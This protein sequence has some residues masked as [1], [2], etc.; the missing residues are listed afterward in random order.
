MTSRRRFNQQERATLY[1]AA[2][3]ACTSCGAA[4]DSGWHGDHIRPYSR[5]G[6]TDVINGQALCPPCNLEKGDRVTDDLR[7]W[8]H[9]AIRKFDSK[10]ATDFLVCATPGAGKTR[11]ALTLARRLLNQQTAQ[12]VVVV[13][14]TDALRRQWADEAAEFGIDLM[15]VSAPEDYDK[16]GYHGCVV[17]YAQLATGAGADLLRRTTRLP[18]VALIDEI[19]HAGD[20]RAWG[21]GVQRA[22]ERAVRR[23]GL[24]GTPWRK[25]KSSPIPF[26][27][28][29]AAGKVIVDSSYEYGSAV[30][31]GVCRRV[32][33]H[34]YDGEARWVDCGTI[35][36]AEIGEKM[37]PEDVA[38]VLDTILDPDRDWMPGILAA[39]VDALRELRREMPDAGGLVVADR[40]AQ[41]QKYARMLEEMTGEA[42][43]VAVSGDPNAPD[44]IEEFR[45]GR[46]SWLVAVKMVSEGVDIKRLAVGVYATKTRT[47]LFFRQVVGRFVRTRPD[48]EINAKLFIPAV[49][50]FTTHAKEIEDELRHQLELEVQRDEA[51][52]REAEAGQQ[53]FEL[54][55]PISAS[56]AQFAS[57]I[58]GGRQN[59]A[60]VHARAEQWCRDRGIPVM[61]AANVINDVLSEGQPVAQVVITPAT[62]AQPRIRHEKMLRGDINTLVG[63][64]AYRARIEPRE[65]NNELLK[66]GFPTRARCDIDQL[67]QIRDHLA[68]WLSGL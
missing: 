19:H 51:A 58:F 56:E 14:P 8:Q 32:E 42:A 16:A 53:M 65:V 17:T 64:I 23:I 10:A 55:E 25:D 66:S 47:P 63:K 3:G 29:D 61:Y 35:V 20:E 37:R 11:L 31:D 48:E 41:A 27:S 7:V 15:P 38:A 1:L 44:R 45:K 54:R 4:L 30:A 40:Q 39:A 34:A 43:T 2:D 6:V 5:G 26:V 49:P 13:V 22:L 24:T 62:P 57:T 68:K 46:S 33:F 18:T 28:Y 59:T 50:A 21:E 9:E 36:S 12:R 60:E 52:T 67:T